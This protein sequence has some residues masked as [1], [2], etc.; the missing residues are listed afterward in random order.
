[1]TSTRRGSL[2]RRHLPMPGLRLLA[3]AAIP[4]ALGSAVLTPSGAAAHAGGHTTRDAGQAVVTSSTS[5]AATQGLRS[6][7]LPGLTGSATVTLITGDQ[8]RLTAVGGGRFSATSVLVPGGSPQIDISAR[9]NPAGVTSLQAVPSDAGR[10]VSTGQVSPGLFDVSYLAS[11]GD[12]GSSARIPVTLQ[13]T[14][15]PGSATLRRDAARLPGATVLATMPG[16][17]VQVSVAATRASAFWA[18]LTGGSPPGATAPASLADGVTG[19]WL[20]GQQPSV[21]GTPAV[22]DGLPLYTVTETISR[23]MNG[24]VDSTDC[25]GWS[26]PLVTSF[27]IDAFVTP[28]LVGVAGSGEDQYYPATNGTGTCVRQRP[29]K[30]APVCTAWQL[31]YSVPAGIYFAN[32]VGSFYSTDNPDH[33]LESTNVELDVPQFTVTGNTAISLN[34]SQAVPVTVT[35]PRPGVD[36]GWPD[37]M[38][39][40]RWTADGGYYMNAVEG[41]LPGYN[42]WWAVPTPAGEGA[43]VGSYHFSPEV[44]LGAP[45]ITA[46]VTAP[47]H[48]TLH[49]TYACAEA[50]GTRAA[51][52]G[53][54]CGAVRFAGRQTLQVVNAGTGTAGD[55]SKINARGKLA[56]IT[57]PLTCTGFS[58]C[59]EPG[60]VLYQQLDYALK[61][62]AAGV[63]TDPGP[64]YNGYPIPLPSLVDILGPL[65]VDEYPHLP[66]ASIDAA[67]GSAVLRMLAKGPVKIT[68]DDSGP[69]PYLYF[70]WFNQEGQIPAS[71]HYTLTAAQL[72]S[73]TATYHSG[74]AF[75]VAGASAAAWHPDDRDVGGLEALTSVPRRLTEYYG[76]LSPDLVWSLQGYGLLT[77]PAPTYDGGTFKLF[78]Q[79]A[80]STLDWNGPLV[81]LGAVTQMT[82][83]F[84]A[85][86][87]NFFAGYCAGCRQGDTFYPIFSLVDGASPATTDGQGGF[88]PGSIHLYN[89]AGQEIP[90]TPVLGLATYQLPAGQAR[91]RLVAPTTT[92]EFTSSRPATDQT[93]DGTLCFGTLNGISAAPCQADP[94]LFLRYDAGLSLTGTVTPG[95]HQLQV[96][97]YHQVSTAPAVTSLKLWTSTDGGTTWQPARVSGGRGGTFTASYTIPASG[98]NGYV[99]IKAQATDAGGDTITQTLINACGIATAPPASTRGSHR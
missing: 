93:P 27:C 92:W 57:G 23:N 2:F 16:G 91:Y 15:S 64:G 65:G 90:D 49:P 78:D 58:E 10:L 24:P 87:G 26:G 84:Q 56:F 86:P 8:V 40:T 60:W 73:V 85:Q 43:T 11:H 62:G 18:A 38:E 97:G 31:S 54:D 14:S 81:A 66:V 63:L 99:S 51:L 9:G 33:T 61:A 47:S 5:A 74:T 19:V 52:G 77:N 6:L 25:T 96:T 88:A 98:T 70:L 53:E 82:D 67:E 29:A 36:Y 83:V 48:L 75:A 20:T 28:Q 42:N 32:A 22:Q 3:V 17:E 4:L 30:P 12:T 1:M 55:F 45:E 89:Q 37:T 50:T 44:T 35:T 34:A 68:L 76:P 79:P 94:L 39:A 13:Y 71:L 80:D 46:A 7:P 59:A 41:H 95:A 69:S 72:A 21:P